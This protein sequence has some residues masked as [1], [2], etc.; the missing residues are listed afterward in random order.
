MYQPNR[1]FDPN[2]LETLLAMSPKSN[3][4]PMSPADNVA[5][6]Y[7]SMGSLDKVLMMIAQAGGLAGLEGS[8]VDP[9]TG[10]KKT[11]FPTGVITNDKLPQAQGNQ[12]TVPIKL[13]ESG[14]DWFIE[15]GVHYW[16]PKGTNKYKRWE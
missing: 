7:G 10:G 14:F 11:N 1:S 2:G 12:R 6:G 16:K 3:Q 15:N 4:Y 5:G 9:T 13:G 8:A